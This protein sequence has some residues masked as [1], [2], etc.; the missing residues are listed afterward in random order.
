[1]NQ[2]IMFKLERITKVI[3]RTA[4]QND[5]GGG[6]GTAMQNDGGIGA[7][8]VIIDHCFMVFGTTF[9]GV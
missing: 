3:N 2:E 9:Q 4:M 7:E 8:F 1:M 6:L 5:G